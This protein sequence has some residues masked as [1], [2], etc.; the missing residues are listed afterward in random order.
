MTDLT[1]RAA[2]T[3]LAAAALA[4]PGTAATLKPADLVDPQARLD[5]FVRMRCRPNGQKGFMWYQGTF[6]GKPHG[7]AAVPLMGVVGFS[8]N[9]AVR[10]ADGSYLYELQEAGYH[11]DLATGDR[12][13]RF[14]NPLNK[15]TV[16]PRHYRSGQRTRFTT[17]GQVLPLANLPDGVQYDGS[18]SPARVLGDQVF[19]TEDLLVRM[20]N[21]KARYEDPREY[22]GPFRTATSLATFAASLGDVLDTA[23]SFTPCTLSYTTVNSWRPWM[24]MGETPGTIT[25]RLM[26]RKLRSPTEVGEPLL[27]WLEQDHPDLLET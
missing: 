17:A 6:F 4:R 14:F 8:W 11:T 2:L 15:L 5:A 26:G 9:T 24:L 22:C 12:L 21:P 20:P 27:G 19:M 18:I 1:R 3:G 7:E 16:E 25:W 13:D 23:Q 10:Q